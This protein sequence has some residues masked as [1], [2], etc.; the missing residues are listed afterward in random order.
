MTELADALNAILYTWKCA[1]GAPH[2]SS[3]PFAPHTFFRL[4]RVV[5][6]RCAA[7][8]NTSRY[9]PNATLYP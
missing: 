8:L 5:E 9:T 6:R 7:F 1:V 4:L 2:A 3:F